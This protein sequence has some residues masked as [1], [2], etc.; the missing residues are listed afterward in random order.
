VQ[1]KNTGQDWFNIASYEFINTS[2]GCLEFI[3]LSGADHAYIWVHDVGSR[4]GRTESGIFS[5]V[6]VTLGGLDNGLYAVESHKTRG[7][8]G[9]IQT[10]NVYTEA[11]KLLL[12]LPDFT[13]DIAVKIKPLCIVVDFNDLA[14]FCRQWL[15][16]GPGLGADLYGSNKV[17]L[18]DYSIFADYWLGC[19]PATW[20]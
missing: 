7:S 20:P 2:E 10:N 19:R 5:G 4:Y 3:G 17:D 1:V 18:M 12:A 15:Q 16:E 14:A 6:S 13:K 11:G 9:I 8:G